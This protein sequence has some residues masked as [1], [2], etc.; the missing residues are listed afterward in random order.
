MKKYM[1]SK[2]RI[3]EYVREVLLYPWIGSRQGKSYEIVGAVVKV[4]VDALLRGER[5]NIAGF[6]T[7][8]IKTSKGYTQFN[9]KLN[10]NQP[11]CKVKVKV[12]VPSRRYVVFRP[13]PALLRFIE[14]ENES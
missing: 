7:F 14:E 4:I 5:V 1:S 12:T 8:S 11:Q 3:S 6:G 9:R 10:G 13:S 2:E